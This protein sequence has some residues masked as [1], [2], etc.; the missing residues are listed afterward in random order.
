MGP[1]WLENF[2]YLTRRMW[3]I[4]KARGNASPGFKDGLMFDSYRGVFEPNTAS[5]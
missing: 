4:G 5:P 1:R 3:G 2:E